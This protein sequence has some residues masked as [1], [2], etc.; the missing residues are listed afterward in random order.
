MLNVLVILKLILDCEKLEIL[1][2]YV[3]K[4]SKSV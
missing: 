4:S 3:P 2:M 1:L